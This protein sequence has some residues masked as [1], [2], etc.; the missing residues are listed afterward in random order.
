MLLMLA[1]LLF[2]VGAAG[3]GV[4]YLV[5]ALGLGLGAALIG[6]GVRGWKSAEAATPERIRADILALAARRNG[7]VSEA[8]IVSALGER[9]GRAPAALQALEAAQACERRV[10]DGATYFVFRSLQPRLLV[11]R[12]AYCEAEMELAAE[13]TKC[14]R[15]G[16]SLETHVEARS[17]AGGTY[18]MDE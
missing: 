12:C 10:K 4:R 7:E 6:L 1:G 18:R 11:R 14:P 17:V 9:A 8:D 2:L 3:R 15:C 13:V 16:G 5:A